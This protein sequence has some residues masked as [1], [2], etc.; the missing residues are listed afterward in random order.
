MGQDAH[1]DRVAPS[2]RT[3]TGERGHGAARAAL[4]VA[5]LA[6]TQVDLII[7]A[8]NTPDYLFP[9][10]ACLVQDALGA[11][12]AGAFD[13]AAGC[14]GFVYALTVADRFIRS[15]V[16]RHVLVIGVETVSRILPWHDPLC[17]YYG[18]GAGAVVLAANEQPGG[19]L[20]FM[21][22]ADGSGSNLIML[23]GGG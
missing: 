20:L 2:C 11:T 18:D 1:G 8:T 15:G 14:S 16:Y 7:C 9:A 6:P 17:A 10:T 13:L 19:L 21:L 3:E 4:T 22:K 23:P 12:N 5:D